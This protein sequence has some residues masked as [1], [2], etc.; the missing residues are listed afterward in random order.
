MFFNQILFHYKTEISARKLYKSMVYQLYIVK[1]YFRKDKTCL[2]IFSFIL[3]VI[4]D[5]CVSI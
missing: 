4:F 5:M 3:V 1:Q 2:F